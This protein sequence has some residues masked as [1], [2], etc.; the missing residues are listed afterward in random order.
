MTKLTDIG[1]P[2]RSRAKQPGYP[3]GPLPGSHKL[4][5][6]RQFVGPPRPPKITVQAAPVDARYRVV[7]GETV[8]EYF[9]AYLPGINPATGKPW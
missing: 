6:L 2:V 1:K 4:P 5:A 7:E 8:P 3:T 9:G